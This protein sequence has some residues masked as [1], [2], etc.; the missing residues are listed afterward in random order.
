MKVELGDTERLVTPFGGLVVFM[1]FL[2]RA[3]Y[4]QAVGRYLPFRP[5]SANAIDPVEIFTLFVLVMVA[6]ARRFARPS[7]LRADVALLAFLTNNSL[8]FPSSAGCPTSSW[9]G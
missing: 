7:L 8:A 1:E 3:G 5:T 9:R 4:R 2:R 6:G